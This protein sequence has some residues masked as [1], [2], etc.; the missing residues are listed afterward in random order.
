MENLLHMLV[1]IC[2]IATNLC[3]FTPLFVAVRSC[4][5]QWWQIT[6]SSHGLTTARS[7][8]LCLL[9]NDLTNRCVC[10]DCLDTCLGRHSQASCMSTHTKKCKQKILL[11]LLG[12]TP[13][14]AIAVSPGRE[15]RAQARNKRT[16]SQHRTLITHTPLYTS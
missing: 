11:L 8:C 12:G 10:E 9:K 15:P 3:S 4:R 1:Q 6:G 16:V 5:S 2:K 14:R 7:S 13:H